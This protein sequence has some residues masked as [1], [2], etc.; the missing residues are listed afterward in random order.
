MVSATVVLLLEYAGRYSRAHD[1]AL[2][3]TKEQ[4]RFI[5]W[6]AEHSQFVTELDDHFGRD[7]SGH[8]FGSV[9]RRLNRFL[10]FAVPFHRRVVDHQEDPGHGSPGYLIVCMICVDVYRDSGFCASWGWHV[11]G[12]VLLSVRVEFLPV[13]V[14]LRLVV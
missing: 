3:V 11:V 7:P 5:H 8:H 10:S 1:H 14:I 13:V 6:Y 2:I 9:R 4:R 12:D